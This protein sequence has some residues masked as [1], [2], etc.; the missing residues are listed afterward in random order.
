MKECVTEIGVDYKDLLER[1]VFALPLLVEGK[2]GTATSV[3]RLEGLG[4]FADELLDDFRDVTESLGLEDEDC[5]LEESEYDAWL[6]RP[7][8]E[9]DEKDIL[10]DPPLS[11]GED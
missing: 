11:S 4:G 2:T 6:S 9:E 10:E 5:Q 8:D 3:D 7:F 1:A